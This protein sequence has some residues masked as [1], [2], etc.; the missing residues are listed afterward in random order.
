M[1]CLVMW[2]VK[3]CLQSKCSRQAATCV[4]VEVQEAGWQTKQWTVATMT[5]GG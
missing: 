5:E 3:T 2:H 4:W 1:F